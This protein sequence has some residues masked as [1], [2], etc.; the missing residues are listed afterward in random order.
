MPAVFLK[1]AFRP[2]DL[3]ESDKPQIALLGR[4]NVGKS[5]LINHLARAKN[6]ARV[7]A[8]PG[9]TQAINLYEFD[10]RYLLIDLP[11]YGYSKA[12]RSRGK[13]FETMISDYLSLARPLKLVLLVIDGRHGLQESDRDVLS[14]L[15]EAELPVVIVF[16]KVD[17]LSNEAAARAMRE[18]RQ[19]YPMFACLPHSTTSSQGLGELRD[20]IERVVRGAAS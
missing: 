4:S 18:V 16:N 5:S 20:A 15:L 7:S 14:Q 13:G 10:G 12:A 6:L 3:P 11:G 8:T 19:E 17:K 9:L 2:D 1:S